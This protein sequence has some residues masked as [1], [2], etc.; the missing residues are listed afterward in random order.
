MDIKKIELNNEINE[1]LE[2]AYALEI[3]MIKNKRYD[4]AKEIR[5]TTSVIVHRLIEVSGLQKNLTAFW[6]D[7]KAL[8]Q[9]IN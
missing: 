6:N 7:K 2:N 3:E 1:T 8:S 4:L 5:R 9:N